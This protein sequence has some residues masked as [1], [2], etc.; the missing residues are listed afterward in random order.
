MVREAKRTKDPA[1][2]CRLFLLGKQNQVGIDEVL[3]FMT[4]FASLSY[5]HSQL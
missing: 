2:L 5:S 4:S 1:V 3:L